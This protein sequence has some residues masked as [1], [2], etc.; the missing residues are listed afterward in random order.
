MLTKKDV[1]NVIEQM[2]ATVG[3]RRHFFRFSLAL[4]F[5]A[6][7]GGGGRF[8]QALFIELFLIF[9]PYG[10]PVTTAG[11]HFEGARYVS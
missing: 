11:R 3:W 8:Q 10:H 7:P 4:L 1:A 5:I 2:G 6:A 9:L